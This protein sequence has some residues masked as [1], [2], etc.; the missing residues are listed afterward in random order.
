[1]IGDTAAA[2]DWGY[3]I[4]LAVMTLCTIVV[5]YTDISRYWIPDEIVYVAALANGISMAGVP[6]S[7]LGGCQDRSCSVL[8]HFLIIN[9][10]YHICIVIVIQ[11]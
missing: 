1:M 2:L 11:I 4:W 10:L 9:S 3:S 6:Y 7:H 5:I 8:L